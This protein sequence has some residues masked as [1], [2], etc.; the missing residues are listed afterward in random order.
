MKR[1]RIDHWRRAAICLLLVGVLAA[2]VV[3]QSNLGT[4][5][6]R[7]TDQSGGVVPGAEVAVINQATG[8]GRVVVT[9][10]EGMYRVSSVQPGIYNIKVEMPGFKT[11]LWEGLKVDTA[12]TTAV[13][14]RLEVGEQSTVVEVIAKGNEAVIQRE[15]AEIGQVVSQ[16]AIV[17][18]PSAGRNTLA[19]AMS[20]PGVLGQP[21]SESPGIYS[22]DPDPGSGLGIGGGR[23]NT[24]VMLVD[25]ANITGV[26]RHRAIMTFS[27]DVTQEF[28]IVSNNFSAEH[29][30]FG[31]G[32]VQTTT[33]SGTNEF[34]GNAYWFHR[35]RLFAARTFGTAIYAPRNADGTMAPNT[36]ATPGCDK[37]PLRRHNLGITAGGPVYIPKIYDGRNKTFF[38]A[39]FEPTRYWNG[40]EGL[41]STPDEAVRQ[42]DFSGMKNANNKWNN[43]YDQFDQDANGQLTLKSTDPTVNF[44]QFP[45]NKI[46]ANRI[47]P[48]SQKLLNLYPL[49]NFALDSGGRSYRGWRS[50]DG[51][52]NRRSFKVD[53][54]LMEDNNL[55]VRYSFSPI[56]AERYFYEPRDYFFGPASYYV[57]HNVVLSDTHAFSPSTVNNFIYNWSWSDFSTDFPDT[58]KTTSAAK[59]LGIETMFP[60]YGAPRINTGF[61][62]NLFQDAQNILEKREGAYNISNTLSILRGNHSFRIGGTLQ[63][64]YMQSNGDL[65]EFYK[66]T[67]GLWAFGNRQT[68]Q[69][70]DGQGGGGEAAASFLLGVPDQVQM[71]ADVVKYRYRWRSYG[72]FFQ[73]DWKVTSNFTLNLGLR[74]DLF[75]PRTEDNHYQMYLDYENPRTWTDATGRDRAG[76]RSYYAGV[77]EARDYLEKLQKAN[78]APR[79]GIA[80]SP[81][82]DGGGPL[83]WL[84]GPGKGVIRAGYGIVYIG[85]T[86]LSDKA[87]PTLKRISDSTNYKAGRGK[88]PDKLLRLGFNVPTYNPDPLSLEVP[89]VG[90]REP[91]DPYYAA[92]LAFDQSALA[93][94][95]HS[96]NFS[97]QWPV[98]NATAVTL[99]YVANRGTH[100][101][102]PIAPS[103]I[104]TMETMNQYYAQGINPAS[105]QVDNLLGLKDNK[106][107]VIKEALYEQLRPYYQAGDLPIRGRNDSFSSY[108]S[109]QVRLERRFADGYQFNMNYTLSK[110]LDDASDADEVGAT[111]SSPVSD[112]FRS[113]FQWPSNRGLDRSLSN[114]DQA[115]V[116]NY[117]FIAE[118]P[119]GR[120]KPLFASNP[121]MSAILGGWQLS[122]NGRVATGMPYQIILGHNNGIPWYSGRLGVRPDVI[123][124]VPL[125]NPNWKKS[126]YKD[127]PYV[128]PLAFAHPAFGELGDAPRTFGTL[129]FPRRTTLDASL[130]RNFRPFKDESKFVQ[131]RAEAFNVLNHPLFK[132]EG[133]AVNLFGT[134]MNSRV[135]L[136]NPDA[137]A[138]PIL[139]Y[140]GP[141]DPNWT[142]AQKDL[143]GQKNT[144]WGKIAAIGESGRVVQLALKIHW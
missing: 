135:N 60:N 64:Q 77:G 28:K 36:C 18:L 73:D 74:Y 85:R 71:R 137:F 56:R 139:N 62:R 5:T 82:F 117:Y 108:H 113:V 133:G 132:M 105:H 55:N 94:F 79:L 57:S 107:V 81:N 66:L 72:G 9:N 129:R 63:N 21:G 7:V 33:K 98:G 128:N 141:A 109:F 12:T 96:W 116:L 31:G 80:W 40:I 38:F 115:H 37:A 20:A 48:V 52:D 122:G 127:V 8:V 16:K 61:S 6:G 43:I 131:L 138:G 29:N 100:L 75:I 3:A 114:Y 118:L 25:G 97:M 112:A 142:Q 92:G 103:N 26:G 140:W 110:S 90:Y 67:G 23:L 144:G 119:F 69:R 78:F 32:I 84:F 83:E 89:A 53:H 125:V 14:M 59:E 70:M 50:V 123:P 111:G 99:A 120:G 134:G 35:Q 2:L 143:N 17:D 91:W 15:D 101:P 65:Y 27:P 44:A 106:G 1:T 45:G 136:D 76:F 95:S 68:T 102:T 86:G 93:P 88:D 46:P 47:S 4:I 124:G 104:P 22:E 39:A 30:S 130:Q 126:N 41:Y 58:W 11:A 19:L 24:T 49:P 13:P 34:H 121:F 42:G 87:A 51:I 54:Q 10:D